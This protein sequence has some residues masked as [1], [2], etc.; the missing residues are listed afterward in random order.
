MS[1]ARKLLLSAGVLAL[2]VLVPEACLRL[3]GY[4]RAGG[5]R[6]G[7]P[8]PQ[9]MTTFQ[10][11][12]LLFW[13]LKRGGRPDVA[14]NSRGFPGPDPA[15]PK[16][17]D[18]YRAVFL[19]DSCTFQGFP[20]V[21]EAE[22]RRL[23][24]PPGLRAEAVSLAVPGYT[25]LQGRRAAE[26][27]G[28]ELQP[29]VVF[30]YF[31][32]NDHWRA[33]GEID[34]RKVLRL[35]RGALAKLAAYVTERSRLAQAAG[36]LFAGLSS[37]DEPLAE[38]RVLPEEYRANLTA[39]AEVF[40]GGPAPVVLV[41]APTSFYRLGVPRR[42]VADGFAASAEDAIRLHRQYNGIAREVAA[43]TGSLLLDLE[44]ECDAAPDLPSRFLAD[45]VHFSPAGRQWLGGRIA[46][47]VR[48]EVL[49]PR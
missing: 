21:A 47:Y 44:A 19:G 33:Y 3:A 24:I 7:Y 13:R 41:T 45:G 23:S 25:S 43:A 14:G 1:S 4:E 29:D 39:I 20:F 6:F 31:G 11:D 37:P 22:M 9:T 32:W 30:V 16:P 26:A 18:V 40:R 36:A 42:L 15:I 2:A 28:K 8:D 38:T 10:P 12:E 27:Y 5:V 34:S 35:P 48:G 49:R 46:E 17:A